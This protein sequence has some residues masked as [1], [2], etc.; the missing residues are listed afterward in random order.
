MRD[1][2]HHITLGMSVNTAEAQF[3]SKIFQVSLN[4]LRIQKCF[5]KN[6][7]VDD[8]WV[9]V[10]YRWFWF[11]FKALIIFQMFLPIF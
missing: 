10:G 4:F 6:L 8:C 7:N 3:P 11:I 5:P 9:M 1:E 2:L